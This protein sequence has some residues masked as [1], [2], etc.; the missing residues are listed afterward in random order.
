MQNLIRELSNQETG[1]PGEGSRLENIVSEG[2]LREPK[3]DVII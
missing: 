2:N 1:V 3:H